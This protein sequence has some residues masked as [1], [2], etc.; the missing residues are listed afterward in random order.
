MADVYR[1]V[2][3]LRRHPAHRARVGRARLAVALLA[4]VAGVLVAIPPASAAAA[5]PFR[6]SSLPLATRVSDAATASGQWIKF[7]SVAWPATATTL[8]ASVARA[9]PA[10]AS[11]Q[12]RLD[13]PTSGTLLGTVTVPSTGDRRTWVDAR[14]T[15]QAASGQHDVYLVFTGA[16]AVNTVTVT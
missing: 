11:I 12:V 10:A 3:A 2:Q 13:H 16:A 5:Y 4:T 15:L 9:G 6:D 14:A 8:T 1:K 7:G